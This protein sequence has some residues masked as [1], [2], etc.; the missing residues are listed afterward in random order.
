MS[1]LQ[2]RRQQARA[3]DV[4]AYQRTDDKTW[5]VFVDSE[6]ILGPRDLHLTKRDAVNLAYRI[7]VAPVPKLLVS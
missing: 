5:D 2:R 6:W 1:R 3:R 4:F 7:A